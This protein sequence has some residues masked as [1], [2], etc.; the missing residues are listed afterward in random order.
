[1][2][3]VQRAK[4]RASLIKLP[5]SRRSTVSNQ[6]DADDDMARRHRVLLERGRQEASINGENT[7]TLSLIRALNVAHSKRANATFDHDTDYLRAQTRQQIAL[8]LSSG[9]LKAMG[10]ADPHG[11]TEA[12]GSPV[13]CSALTCFR[14]SGDEAP[15]E[16]EPVP[17]CE[18]PVAPPPRAYVRPSEM[19]LR[20]E[21]IERRPSSATALVILPQTPPPEPSQADDE[22]KLRREDIEQR[23][24]WFWGGLRERK[25]E[26]QPVSGGLYWGGRTERDIPDQDNGGSMDETARLSLPAITEEAS[27]ESAEEG[28][29]EKDPQE[30]KAPEESLD[31]HKPVANDD[32][33]REEALVSD[34]KERDTGIFA[35]LGESRRALEAALKAEARMVDELKRTT[36]SATLAK[37]AAALTGTGGD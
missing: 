3:V 1:M 33:P 7:K 26:E 18:V 22:V 19:R 13:S 16:T 8:A 29:Q 21:D 2:S 5:V 34:L 12:A 4:V 25:K 20:P 35:E 28:K 11:R 9:A 24:A 17:F 32:Q 10:L 30:E 27:E 15:P 6:L 37:V 14:G 23:A 36:V 31:N